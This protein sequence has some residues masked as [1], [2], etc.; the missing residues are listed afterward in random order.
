MENAQ[1]RLGSK[2]FTSYGS[3]WWSLRLGLAICRGECQ[4]GG[5]CTKPEHCSCTAGWTGKT[6]S[7][8][9]DECAKRE[10]N[11]DH[12]C[13]NTPGSFRCACKDGYV[14][15]ED[16]KTC[17]KRNT[18][19]TERE[20][21]SELLKKMETMQKRIESLE[22]WQRQVLSQD[23]GDQRDD[24][25]NSLSEQIAILEERLEECSCNKRDTIQFPA[26]QK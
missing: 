9:I 6:C 20:L 13:I 22:E 12:D 21:D 5:T 7:A 2:K 3:K 4:N 16:G 1:Y 14:L 15:Q 8:D 10:D 26:A 11:C 25:I 23:A 17:E 19:R 24:R 18:T